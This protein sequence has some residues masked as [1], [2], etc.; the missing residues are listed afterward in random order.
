[1]K[2]RNHKEV[3]TNIYD[4]EVWGKGKGSGTG[5]SI[6]YCKRYVE[7]LEKFLIDNKIKRVLDLGCGDWQF[8]QHVNWGKSKYVGLDVVKSVIRANKRQFTTT[9]IKFKVTDISKPNLIEPYL[10]DDVRQ[11]ILIKDVLMHWNDKEIIKWMKKFYKLIGPN[12]YVLITNNYK[13]MR[14]P[15][16]NDLPRELDKYSWSPLDSQKK[17][18]IKWN[19]EVVFK[20]R[21]KQVSLIKK[22][23]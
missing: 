14:S 2:I 22:E 9:G 13:H 8:S 7:F 4:K 17:P 5:S 16:K 11:V 12:H 21:V 18:L 1:M 3:F 10:K 15:H 23:K 20:Y 19:P 6:D